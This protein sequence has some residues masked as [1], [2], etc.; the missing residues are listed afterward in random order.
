MN[1]E[2]LDVF[3]LAHELTLRVYKITS[4]FPDIEKYCL[5]SQMRRAASSVCMNLAEGAHRSSTNEY[6]HFISISK[7]SCGEVRYQLRL[8][9][10]LAYISDS[11]YQDISPG[12]ERVSMMLTKLHASL[13]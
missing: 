3:K 6:R 7:G 9:R 4:T 10:D 13:K 11:D 2:D 5:V 12:Y 1:V 8:S